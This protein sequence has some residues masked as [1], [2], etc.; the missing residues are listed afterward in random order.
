MMEDCWSVSEN[1]SAKRHKADT[2]FTTYSAPM[3][4]PEPTVKAGNFKLAKMID[5]DM[6][7]FQINPKEPGYNRLPRKVEFVQLVHKTTY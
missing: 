6:T 7:G 3:G 4:R 5:N 1:R 2:K